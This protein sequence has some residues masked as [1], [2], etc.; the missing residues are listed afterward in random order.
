MTF[1]QHPPAPARVSAEIPWWTW[2]AISDPTPLR[3]HWVTGG[4]GGGKSHGGQI[5]D[6]KRCLENGVP[7]SEARPSKSWTV[8][9]NYLICDTLME[10]TLQVAQDVFNL[11]EGKHFKLYLSSPK[12]I[13]F[14]PMGLKHEL[15]FRSA[16]NPKHFVSDSITHWRWS[17]PGVSKPEVFNQ[18]MNRLRDKRAKCL[19]GLADGTPEGLNHYSDLA[20]IPGVGR[21]RLD[22][23]RNFRRFIVETGDNAHNLVAGYLEALRERYAYDQSRLLSYEKGLFVPF[24][25]GS[26]YW[27]FVESRNVVHDV[28][29]SPHLPL[30]VTFDFN[31]SP[32]AV[33][34]LQEFTHQKTYYAPRTKK[35]VALW[36]SSGE[37]RGLLDAIAEFGT[38]FPP[39]VFRHT[40][41]EVY[42]DASG[43]AR[44]HNSPGSDYHTIDTYLRSPALGYTN[45]EVRATKS[46]PEIRQRLEKTAALMAYERF[47]VNATCRRLIQSFVKT[48]L[49]PGTWQIEKPPGEDWTHWADAC[50]YALYQLARDIDVAN[51]NSRRVLGAA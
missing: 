50:T 7:V 5:W 4:L 12:T 26:G 34:V 45:V 41:I 44:H 21:D 8:A 14:T 42:G 46:N 33:I 16:D 48:A 30:I 36:E 22:P 39:S 13:D 51:P 31:V 35:L 40:P 17:E 25:K 3:T 18:L 24:N 11:R 2:D 1:Q 47:T 28:R 19:Q 49:K 20:D 37:S 15:S 23:K 27:E 43:Y 9:P 38:A 29:P 6:I 10:L 32:L